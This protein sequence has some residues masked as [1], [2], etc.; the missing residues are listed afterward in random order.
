MYEIENDG[1]YPIFFHLP[2]PQSVS[3]LQLWFESA[4][5]PQ[6]VWPD[7]P[8]NMVNISNNYIGITHSFCKVR[9]KRKNNVIVVFQINKLIVVFSSNS[10]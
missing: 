1:K 4:P 5:D 6:F 2:A 7:T 3:Y 10:W 9:N 8:F